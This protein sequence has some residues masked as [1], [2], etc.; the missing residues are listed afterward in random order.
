MAAKI[1]E[2]KVQGKYSPRAWG[3]YKLVPELRL[4][5]IWLLENGFH[6]GSKVE[7]TVAE[8]QLII[9]AL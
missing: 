1:K 8:K 7:I 5:G 4:N 6:A 3:S 2:I 9:K